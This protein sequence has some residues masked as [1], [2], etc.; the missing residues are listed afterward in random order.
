MRQS[1]VTI[2]VTGA[3]APVAL[4]IARSFLAL[5]QEVHLVDSVAATAASW[6]RPA[7]PLHRLP[8]PRTEFDAFRTTLAEVVRTTGAEL[9]VPTCE[10]V[11]YLAAAAPPIALFAPPLAMLRQLHSK[12]AFIDLARVAGVAVPQTRRI[13]DPA[14][15]AALPLDQLV[16][17]PE[18][19]RFAAATL[20]RPD[21]HAIRRL[22]PTPDHA[23]VA[24]A[25]VEGEELCL[26]TAA[27]EGRL[28]AHALYRPALRHGRSAAYAFEAIQ[29]QPAIR[30][31]EAIAAATKMTGHLS[32][33]LIRTPDGHAVPIECNPRAVSGVH[34]FDGDTLARAILGEAQAAPAPGTRRH[35]A[36][37]MAVLGLPAA[38]SGHSRVL[39]Y[40]RNGR[41]AISRPGDRWPIAGAVID[42]ARFAALGLS[43]H[44]SPT[45]Q[46]TADIEWNGEPIG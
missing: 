44:R 35:L 29:W 20:I 25:F 42:A 9:I 14:T 6:S 10:E 5:G 7:F 26:W 43:R 27:H 11:F 37:A 36:P 2:L 8:A 28:T 33:D 21:R 41:D 38:L 32:F 40:W 24:Q 46:T 17:K 13:T 31:A 4:D 18:Y 19:S 3:R 16:L 23:W 30:M 12:A 1:A 15:L 39:E 34:L 22:R 45:R